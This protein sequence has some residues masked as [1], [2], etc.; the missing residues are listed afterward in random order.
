V[1]K[2]VDGTIASRSCE[3]EVSL[4]SLQSADSSKN[5]KNQSKMNS[6]NDATMNKKRVLAAFLLSLL[7]SM[8]IGQT[9]AQTE[10]PTPGVSP[11]DVFTYNFSVH[12]SSTDP[13]AMPPAELVELNKT[14]TI[15]ITIT[16]VDGLMVLM[17]ITSRFENGTESTTNGMVNILS[18]EDIRGFGLVIAPDLGTDDIVYPAGVRS[19]MINSTGTSTYS[20]GV[21]ETCHSSMN[22][23]D[24]EG[25]VYYFDSLFFDRKTGAMLEWY[26]E[27]VSSSSP[28]EKT[29]YQWKINEF[30]LNTVANISDYWP[31]IFAAVAV[32]GVAVL[33][34]VIVFMRKNRKRRRRR[35]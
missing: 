16:E 1:W 32:V 25:F 28:N 13:N 10:Q 6:T 18:G 23:T 30:D 22:S 12:W 5:N 35:K 4:L 8:M 24:V 7:F 9:L 3:T 11:G 31:L 2:H 21:R 20:F 33:L 29:A 27:Q 17:N 19:F 26:I 34:V 14:K 15:Q